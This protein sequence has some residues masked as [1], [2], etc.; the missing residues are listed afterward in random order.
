[1]CV[2]LF[3]CSFGIVSPA[4]NGFIAGHMT[5]PAL[6]H[7][8]PEQWQIPDTWLHHNDGH[9]RRKLERIKAE[10]IFL[11]FVMFT[12]FQIFHICS[13]YFLCLLSMMFIESPA[14]LELLGLLL[15]QAL[16]ANSACMMGAFQANAEG[17]VVAGTSEGEQQLQCFCM[18]C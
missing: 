10:S 17:C 2:Q 9:S 8:E 14:N 12:L 4:R 3:S 1:M 13:Y 11:E 16:A 7:T 18:F 5:V 15:C 6:P